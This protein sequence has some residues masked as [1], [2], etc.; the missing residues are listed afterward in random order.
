ML[1]RC[2]FD[3]LELPEGEDADGACRALQRY[4]VAYQ[5]GS[6]QRPSAD[7]A[8]SPRPATYAAALALGQRS[9]RKQLVHL[10]GRGSAMRPV[11][12]APVQVRRQQ[13]RKLIH[14]LA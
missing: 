4:D 10:L 9:I 7:S 6:P 5:P 2:G 14:V 12:Q 13:L 1:A 8:S 3:A 11:H